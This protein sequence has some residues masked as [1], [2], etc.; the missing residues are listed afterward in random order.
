MRVE[1]KKLSDT[2]QLPVRGSEQAAGYD[3]CA[4]IAEQLEIAPGETAKVTTGLAFAIPEGYFGGIFAR[5]GLS[6]KKGLR[7]A[8]CS[9]VVDS[10]YRGPVI[11]ALH[12]DSTQTRVIEPG[13]RIAQLI[14]LPYLAA[15]FD[16]VEELDETD[17]GCGGFGSTGTK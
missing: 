7:P 1:V 8:N 5:S 13:E 4:D 6:T 14:L 11:V 3:L 9:G 12:N 2:A 17:R 10:D 16:E 15:E